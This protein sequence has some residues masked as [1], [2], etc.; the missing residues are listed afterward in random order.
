M[1]DCEKVTLLLM[2]NLALVV[3]SNVLTA[4]SAGTGGEGE[5]EWRIDVLFN[6]GGNVS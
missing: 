3:K 5:K 4:V 6:S 1:G 2:N